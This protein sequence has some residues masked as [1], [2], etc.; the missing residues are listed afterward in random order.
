M[1]AP[2]TSSSLGRVQ[3]ERAGGLV[4][5]QQRVEE[6]GAAVAAL[7]CDP[8][9]LGQQTRLVEAVAQ[10]LA[11]WPVAAEVMRAGVCPADVDVHADGDGDVHPDADAPAGVSARG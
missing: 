5:D 3:V 2:E 4:G 6:F 10:W 1:P 9:A 7:Q 11:R 8:G